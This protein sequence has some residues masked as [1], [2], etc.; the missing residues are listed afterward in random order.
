MPLFLKEVDFMIIKLLKCNDDKRKLEKTFIDR[1][2][3]D[4]AKVKENTSVFEPTIIINKK[5]IN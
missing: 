2:V 1:K 3:Y 5:I 4:N